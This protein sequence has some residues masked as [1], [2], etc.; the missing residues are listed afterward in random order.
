MN[1]EGKVVKVSVAQK[2]KGEDSYAE[3]TITIK[4]ERAEVWQ[5]DMISEMVATD[6]LRSMSI[7]EPV[8]ESA[9]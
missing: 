6:V 8:P 3:G 1:F 5:L 9:E 7:G 4:T 2:G